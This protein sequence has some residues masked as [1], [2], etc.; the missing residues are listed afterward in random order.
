MKHDKPVGTFLA[1]VRAVES[2][3]HKDGLDLDPT[4]I[5]LF[6]LNGLSDKFQP[7]RQSFYMYGKKHGQ[8]SCWEAL[9]RAMEGLTDTCSN[10]PGLMVNHKEYIDTGPGTIN[11]N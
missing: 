10:H 3:L 7:I 9:C 1:R 8:L 6:V 2:N 11:S 4:L 5:T